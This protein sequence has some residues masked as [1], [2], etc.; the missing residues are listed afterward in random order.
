MKNSLDIL[1]LESSYSEIDAEGMRKHLNNFPLL[2]RRAWAEAGEIKLPESFKDINK[3]LI[4]GM[5]GSAIGGDLILNYL[6]EEASVPIVLHRSYRLPAYVDDRTL[7]IA[8]S[9]SGKTEE[10][11]FAFKEA[12]KTNAKKMVIAT[13]GALEQIALE[14]N[15]TSYIFSYNSQPRAAL[16]FTF[17]CLL[18]F[19]I[20][21]EVIESGEET[22]KQMLSSLDDAVSACNERLPL[23]K[24]EAK[25]VAGELY[26][27][28][29]VIY[30]VEAT[31]E[32]AHRWKTQINENSKTWA[33][34][35]TFSELNHN[36]M[37]GYIYP[38]EVSEKIK[39]IILK[40][41]TISN[42]NAKRIEITKEILDEAGISHITLKISGENKLC[43]TMKA[44]LL[45]DYVSYYL[46]ILYGVDPTPIDKL[47]YLKSK[48]SESF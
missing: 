5:G 14:N 34:Y 33:F 48:L 36:A 17:C 4:L 40:P 46:S 19:F 10:T 8:S 31:A 16:P 7:V 3:I 47:N 32:A 23:E 39:V 37:E 22:F 27:T 25:R 41:V 29:P 12:L 1:D 44:V 43:Q 26:G 24:N 2:C 11:I 21:L 13:G 30:G 38:K 18:N 6:A 42:R 35:D 15:I 20:R 45:G 28:L 9:Y